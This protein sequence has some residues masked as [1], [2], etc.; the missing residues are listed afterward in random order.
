MQTHLVL[1]VIAEDQP[2][3]VEKISSTVTSMGGNWLESSMINLAGKFAGVALVEVPKNRQSDL[4]D[5][6]KTLKE[7][8]I[9]VT[10]ETSL[11]EF[12]SK[13]GEPVLLKIVANDRPG[14][15]QEFSQLFS[16]L[17]VNVEALDTYCESAAMSSEQ[18]FEATATVVMP[19]G[20]D[21]DDLASSLESLSDD[22]MVEFIEFDEE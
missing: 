5:A 6:L 12:E 18:L 13:A 19:I 2:G 14:I 15:V 9:R 4:C 7:V 11:S 8:G 16:S 17:N 21:F 1:T 20:M 22:L 3:I 10:V